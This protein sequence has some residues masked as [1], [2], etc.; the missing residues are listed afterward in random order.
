MNRSREQ[1]ESK[2]LHNTEVSWPIITDHFDILQNV[3]ASFNT[4]LLTP[5]ELK[6]VDCLLQNQSL[7]L[8]EKSATEPFSF[9]IDYNH[10]SLGNSSVDFYQNDRHSRNRGLLKISLLQCYELLWIHNI[11]AICKCQQ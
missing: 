4:L 9:R 5:S 6:L 11:D 2:V 1:Y 10:N 7:K 3:I 8:L